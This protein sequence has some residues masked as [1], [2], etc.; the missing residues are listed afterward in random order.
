MSRTPNKRKEA[1][2]E[3]EPELVKMSKLARASGVPASTIKHYMREGLLPGPPLRT[4]R[5]MSYYDVR[6]VPRIRAIK[7]LQRTRYLPLKVIKDLLSSVNADVDDAQL[8]AAIT[9]ALGERERGDSRTRD[10]ITAAGYPAQEL[11]WFEEIGLVTSEGTGAERR[12]RGNDLELL[13]TLHSARL[14]G[15]TPDML[16]P[17][18]LEPYMEAVR[19]LVRLEIEMFRAGVIPRAG[20]RLM[21]LAEVATELSERLI[22]LLRRKLILP[23]LEA[24]LSGAASSPSPQ[25]ARQRARP[26]RVGVRPS[27]GPG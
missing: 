15:L 26:R 18:I 27:S 9:R 4:S 16:P 19:E 21:D 7:E 3:A 24:T 8:R 14:R 12:F 25:R 11:D 5:N 6:L 20:D 1:R 2:Q 23:T 22:V 10:E 13:E 17:S